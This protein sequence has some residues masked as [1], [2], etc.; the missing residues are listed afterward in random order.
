MTTC[1][2]CAR[3]ADHA[4]GL[5]HNHYEQY[6]VR[7]NAYGR[8]ETLRIDADPARQH[9]RALQAAGMGTRRIAELAGCSRGVISAL[10][11]GRTDRGEPPS[12]TMDREYSAAILAI[13]IPEIPHEVVKPGQIVP[14]I[15][16]ARRLQALVCLGY[17]QAYLSARVGF[18]PSNGA[19][20]FDPARQASVT[21]STA[22]RAAQLFAELQLTPG[23]SDQARRR[24]Q[25]A[26]WAPPLAWDDDTI[27][28]PKAKPQHQVRRRATFVE[29][30]TEV[31]D[32]CGITEITAIASALGQDPKSVERQAAR[33]RDRLEE[34]AS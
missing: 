21:A 20:L 9:V 4:R 33:Y 6:R 30:F 18:L 15:G 7:Q 17:T 1:S 23:P 5:C 22:R 19:R 25:R 3:P 8:W 27:D 16:T 29:R 11:N 28:D 10:I 12:K 32:H 24:A 13:E 2:K 26:G 31:R 14:S 34:V